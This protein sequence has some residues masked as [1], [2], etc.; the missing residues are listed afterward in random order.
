MVLTEILLDY[1]IYLLQARY[2]FLSKKCYDNYIKQVETSFCNNP[3][4]FWDFLRKNRT[5]SNLPTTA[6]I[7]NG[8][9]FEAFSKHSQFDFIFLDITKAF[10]RVNHCALLSILLNLEFGE[11]LLS[12]F[13]SYLSERKQLVKINGFCFSPFSVTPRW[14]SITRCFCIFC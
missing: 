12:W 10:D 14:A 5:F 2:K 3:K 6:L 13:S 11:F 8:Y 9:V 1:T 4:S 7:F